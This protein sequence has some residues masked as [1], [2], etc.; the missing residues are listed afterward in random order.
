MNFAVSVARDNLACLGICFGKFTKTGK[1]KLHITALDVLS[2]YAKFKIWIKPN[3]EM[4]FLYGN[5][6]VKAHLGRITQ[7]TPEHQG[8]IL[9]SMNDTPLGFGV[10]ARSTADVKN[11][12]PTGI[13]VFHQADIGEYL[14]HEQDLL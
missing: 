4:P 7:D 8:V 13:L 5:N 11:L 9:M 3:G 14:R 1:F 6:V 10:M 12:A 2:Q